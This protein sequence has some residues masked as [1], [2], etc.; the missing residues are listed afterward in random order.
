[1]CEI[2][3]SSNRINTSSVSLH[4]LSDRGLTN[5]ISW[6]EQGGAGLQLSLCPHLLFPFLSFPFLSFPLTLSLFFFTSLPLSS[7]PPLSSLLSSPPHFHV[8]FSLMNLLSH[9][10]TAPMSVF[11][12][13]LPSCFCVGQTEPCPVSCSDSSTATSLNTEQ[14]HLSWTTTVKILD[15]SSSS[16]PRPLPLLLVLFLFLSSSSSS[17]PPR[18]LP[19]LL[20]LFLFLFLSSS[21]RLTSCF[22]LLSPH[23]L[24]PLICSDLLSSSSHLSSSSSSSSS[25][26]S[27]N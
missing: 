5:K 16:P 3:N 21:S 14:L 23:F 26:W 7:P 19:L 6:G 22:D 24:L 27:L 1:M 17:S 9:P 13:F 4:A 8:V 15:S 10:K 25:L 2:Q 11:P 12:S 20:I 18:P